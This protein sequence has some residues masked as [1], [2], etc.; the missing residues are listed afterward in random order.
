MNRALR[1]AWSHRSRRGAPAARS[2]SPR[3]RRLSLAVNVRRWG[4][5]KSSGDEAAGAGTS[6]G[7]RPAAVPAPAAAKISLSVVRGI[8]IPMCHLTP[9]RVN[10]RGLMSHHHWHGGVDALY[11]EATLAASPAAASRC[12]RARLAGVS[13]SAG[14][15]TAVNARVARV[16]RYFICAFNSCWSHDTDAGGRGV[17]HARPD[18]YC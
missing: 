11:C 12:R 6:V 3:M 14:T 8:T 7:L 17:F 1:A 4:R 13:A 9:S 15:A 10:F 16:E 18:F 2:T 5:S